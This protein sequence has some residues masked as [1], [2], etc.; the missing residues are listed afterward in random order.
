MKWRLWCW[1]EQKIKAVGAG[2]MSH[3]P[4]RGKPTPDKNGRYQSV[5]LSLSFSFPFSFTLQRNLVTGRS[6][7]SRVDGR[8]QSENEKVLL[9][10]TIS[11]RVV[12]QPK[13]GVSAGRP[14]PTSRGLAIPPTTPGLH[15]TGSAPQL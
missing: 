5:F 15:H 1:V 14:R 6:L 7:G 8:S 2:R 3:L 10:K 11:R 13:C 9:C 12:Y 4:G